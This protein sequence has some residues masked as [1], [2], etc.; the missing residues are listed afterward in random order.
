VY[1]ERQHFLSSEN[2]DSIMTVQKKMQ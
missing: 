2:I 1:D